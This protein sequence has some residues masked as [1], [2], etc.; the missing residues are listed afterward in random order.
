MGPTRYH[1]GV[2][3]EPIFLK[4]S[5]NFDGAPKTVEIRKDGQTECD[6]QHCIIPG[7]QFNAS[8][9]TG[10][11]YVS[12]LGKC[13]YHEKSLGKLQKNLYSGHLD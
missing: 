4:Y 2:L 13:M 5:G 12:L 3:F 7:L 10:Q 8:E 11:E 6:P 1:E 9:L